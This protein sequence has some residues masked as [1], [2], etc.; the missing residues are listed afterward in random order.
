MTRTVA[1]VQASAWDC[2]SAV[3]EVSQTPE[4]EEALGLLG[5]LAEL[6]LE[7]GR[8]GRHISRWPEEGLFKLFGLLEL[9]MITEALEARAGLGFSADRLLGLFGLLGLLE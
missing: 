3:T 4:L 2:A 6:G 5:L 7:P 1:L 8:V 9:F